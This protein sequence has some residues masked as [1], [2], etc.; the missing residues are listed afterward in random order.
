L[1]TCGGSKSPIA[2]RLGPWRFKVSPAED[3]L[4]S[5]IPSGSNQGFFTIRA[6]HLHQVRD[7]VDECLGQLSDDLVCVGQFHRFLYLSLPG[8]N[9]GFQK[10]A[11][12]ECTVWATT[13][14]GKNRPYSFDI[15]NDLVRVA[16]GAGRTGKLYIPL[17]HV[18]T[19]AAMHLLWR[20]GKPIPP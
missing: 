11:I 15:N 13:H 19:A 7:D 1:F 5:P 10:H 20:G 2:I 16:M 9:D 6:R 12:G 14:R 4:S 18:E 3:A 8:W 17:Q